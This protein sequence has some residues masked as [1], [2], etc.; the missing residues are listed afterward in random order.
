MVRL[1]LIGLG[2]MGVS[3]LAIMRTHPDAE[4]VAVCDTT[5]YVIDTLA[6]YTGVEVY[7]DY[8]RMLREKQLDGVVI[9][10]PSRFHAEMVRDA[11]E[12]GVH[13]FCEK[14]FC[15]DPDVGQR[16]ADLA[17]QRGLV[18]QVG[19]H[20]RFV[21]AFRE[22]KRLIDGGALGRL[23]HF[24]AEAYGPVVLRPKNSTWRASK[25]EGGG[26]LYDYASHAI[27]LVN[28][29]LGEPERVGGTV[30]NT[31]FSRDVEDEV[32]ATLFLA[33]GVTGQ[34]AANWSEDSHRKMST[35][36]SFW[37]TNGRLTVD[38]QETQLY[39]RDPSV[40]SIPLKA[41]WTMSYTT[42][43]SENQAFYLRGE[44]YSAQIDHF[45]R[46]IASGDT[47]TVSTF[48]T[49]VATDRVAAMMKRDAAGLPEPAA[50]SGLVASG[51][52]AVSSPL[53]PSATLVRPVRAPW[54][55][56]FRRARA[57]VS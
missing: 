42:G 35:K 38:R 43:L 16:L 37:G 33:G 23:H 55:A 56:L 48:A 9:A 47:D 7:S 5:R 2:K 22:A 36:M 53:P 46:A 15:L 27:D 20:Y 32:Y 8:K 4:L 49:A 57:L 51:S 11:L 25:S 31:I 26:C 6:K 44:E 34:I 21:S 39:V 30:L 13:V 52:A 18:N 50:A 1:G 19:Y 45:V 14:P 28:F 3:H 12:H 10:T 29:L 41:G 17:R 24:R 54:P 40:A